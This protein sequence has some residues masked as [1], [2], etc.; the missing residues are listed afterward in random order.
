MGLGN[1]SMGANS[2]NRGSN[3]NYEFRSLQ[4][5]SQIVNNVSGSVGGAATE[6]T[7]Q[8]VLNTLNS[9]KDVE[10][11]LIKDTGNSDKIVQQIK[12]YDQ[13]TG[14]WN[15]TYE[16]ADGTPYIPVGPLVYLD[17]SSILNLLLNELLTLNSKDFST[18]STLSTVATPV[19]NI[20]VNVIRSTTAGANTIGAGKR[21]I[22]FFN[23]G[24]AD[25]NVGGSILKAGEVISF[26]ADGLRDSLS[27]VSY[28]SLTSE[29]LIT[30]VG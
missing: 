8:S 18:E 11:L 19:V 10:I 14:T 13:G 4:L 3:F 2:G 25:T 7:L 22:S 9:N 17:I 26:S 27:S 5:L 21:R 6:A 30:T 15:T 12:K 24:N 16:E 20:P 28:D 23:A 29:L 1:N